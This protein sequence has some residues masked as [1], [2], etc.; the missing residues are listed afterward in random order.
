MVPLACTRS[1]F[2]AR[3]LTARLGAD[4]IV[5]ELRGGSPDSVYPLGAID[6]LVAEDDLDRAR[7][8]LSDE[9][10]SDADAPDELERRAWL[11][12]ALVVL[13]LVAFVALRTFSL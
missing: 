11:M 6:I 8:L 1:P 12:P 5:W 9:V 7:E 3:V 13:G 2:E 4:G 10:A